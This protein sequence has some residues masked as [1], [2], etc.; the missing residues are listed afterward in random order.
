M[1]FVTFEIAKKLKEKGYPQVKKN[2]LAMYDEV[3]YW[4]SLAKNLDDF[5]YL[6]VDFDEH[7]CVCPTIAQVLEWLREEH[8]LHFEVLSTVY[9]YRLSISDTPD[10]GGTGRYFS[11]ANDDGTND[12]GAWDRYEDCV[13]YGIKYFLDNLI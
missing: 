11:H 13:L 2:T 9:G 3:G 7:D 1:E 8:C 6:F 12:C 4:C 10:K 5:E